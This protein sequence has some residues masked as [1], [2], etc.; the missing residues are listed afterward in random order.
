VNA[1]YRDQNSVSRSSGAR[2]A[3][4]PATDVTRAA[5]FAI[6]LRDQTP[7]SNSAINFRDQRDACAA[8]DFFF[9]TFL[10]AR[11]ASDKPIAMACFRLLTLLPERPLFNVP[12]SNSCI[13][14][15]TFLDAASL[16]FFSMTSHASAD[17]QDQQNNE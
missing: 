14:F 1:M 13:D 3:R 15:P 8:A 4:G 7:R 2:R 12:R 9:G 17:D 16:Y 10:P 6:K 11:R 5:A